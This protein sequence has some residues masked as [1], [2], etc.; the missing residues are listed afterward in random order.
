[1]RNFASITALAIGVAIFAGSARGANYKDSASATAAANSAKARIEAARERRISITDQIATLQAVRNESRAY[2]RDLDRIEA[3]MREKAKKLARLRWEKANALE[4]LRLGLYCS[5]CM[6]SKTEIESQGTGFYDHLQDVHGHPIPA[7]QEQIDAK[8]RDFDAKIQAVLNE[9]QGLQ[10]EERAALAERDKEDRE[11]VAKINALQSLLGTAMGEEGAARSEYNQ[12]TNEASVLAQK[13]RWQ[14]G[15]EKLRKE[16][17]ARSRVADEALKRKKEEWDL[18]N[19]DRQKRDA[20]RRELQAMS[21]AELL[22]RRREL[23]A[24]QQQ[25]AEA[26]AARQQADQLQRQREELAAQRARDAPPSEAPAS[27]RT[28]AEPVRPPDPVADFRARVDS[29]FPK[30]AQTGYLDQPSI[31][32]LSAPP[33]QDV[34]D[35]WGTKFDAAMTQ[36]RESL[37]NLT[38]RAR[39]ALREQLTETIKGLPDRMLDN[40]LEYGPPTFN[41]RIQQGAST[42]LEQLSSSGSEA[43][44]PKSLGGR[45]FA[46]LKEHVIDAISERATDEARK[47]VV[48]YAANSL[49]SE[50]V[51]SEATQ[52]AQRDFE[53]TVSPANLIWNTFPLYGGRAIKGLKTYLTDVQTSFWNYFK[54]ATDDIMRTPTDD[55]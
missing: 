11:A 25:L 28:P 12:A 1:M 20:E 7:T 50:P 18:A 36:A 19:I 33:A 55:Q 23:D 4:E 3:R 13:E 41:E 53:N 37:G 2:K 21:L 54:F 38:G 46:T 40:A 47:R 8:A 32:E 52:R 15:L 27:P 5:Q 6:R 34:T 9:L 14:A 16:Q 29:I 26:R 24:Q 44:E 42:T 30:V 45:L 51:G 31:E 48:D 39:D 35:M 10:G 17:E 49:R 43:A 22:A